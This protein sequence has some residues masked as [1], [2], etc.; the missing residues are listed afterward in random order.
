MRES[1]NIALQAG[2]DEKLIM[3]DPGVGFAKSYEQN[4][5][6]T[7]N[8]G[9]LKELG[10]PVLLATSRKSMIGNAINEDKDHRLEGTIA[11][12]CYGVL[13]GCQFVRVHDVKE[14]LRAIRMME[15]IVSERGTM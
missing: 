13:N 9:R 11:T 5:E 1:I 15:A 8:V 7:K 14:N 3:V 2:V 10:Y 6:V 12:S 4:L